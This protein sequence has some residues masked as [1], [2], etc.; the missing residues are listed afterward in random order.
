MKLHEIGL[1]LRPQA[2]LVHVPERLAEVQKAFHGIIFL[3]TFWDSHNFKSRSRFLRLKCVS[4]STPWEQCCQL[5]EHSGQ[6]C[7]NTPAFQPSTTTPEKSASRLCNSLRLE[8]RLFIQS[9][10]AFSGVIVRDTNDKNRAMEEDGLS[11][12][13]TIIGVHFL[14]QVRLSKNRRQYS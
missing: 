13:V 3:G 1:N 5:W 10:R 8:S 6:N 11:I 4:D 9:V 12:D 14:K 2:L 7:K